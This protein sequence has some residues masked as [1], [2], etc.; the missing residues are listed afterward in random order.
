VLVL[1]VRQA[2]ASCLT[3]A[4]RRV[5]DAVEIAEQVVERVAAS[6]RLA[7]GAAACFARG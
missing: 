7:A 1:A 6:A 3:H 4:R 2:T 5:L